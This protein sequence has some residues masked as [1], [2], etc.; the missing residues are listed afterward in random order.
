MWHYAIG[1]GKAMQLV[2]FGVVLMLAGCTTVPRPHTSPLDPQRSEQI[3]AA[4]TAREQHLSMIQGLFRASITGP[5]PLTHAVNGVMYYQRPHFLRVKGLTQWGGIL[6]DF[7]QQHETFTL[8]VPGVASRTLVGSLDQL[9]AIDD[10]GRPVRLTLHALRPMVGRIR[11]NSDQ[12]LVFEE[13][14]RF[15]LELYGKAQDTSRILHTRLWVDA[16][17]YEPLRMECLDAEGTPIFTVSYDDYRTIPSASSES[18]VPLMRLPFRIQAE[19]A[20]RSITV[21]MTFVEILATI[22]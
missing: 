3:L 5:I 2:C 21:T 8:H 12:I 11:H 14:N 20:E 15:R 16:Q 18:T 13:G 7:Q 10:F 1:V 9:D 19:D 22:V 6:F 17:G 4:L